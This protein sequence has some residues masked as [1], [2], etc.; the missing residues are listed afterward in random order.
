MIMPIRA[1]VSVLASVYIAGLA[2]IFVRWDAERGRVDAVIMDIVCGLLTLA[3]V[4]CAIW[5]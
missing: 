3:A 4:L 1:L 5:T 2:A